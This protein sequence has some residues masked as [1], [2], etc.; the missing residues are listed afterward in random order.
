[1]NTAKIAELKKIAE[2]AGAAHEAEKNRLA[3]QGLKS[4]VRYELLKPLKASADAA[5]A[6]YAK[7]AKGQISKELNKIIAADLPNRQAAARARSPWKQAKYDA[8]QRA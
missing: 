8:A 1:M 4:Q 7:F 3:A 2:Q 6:E 5:H